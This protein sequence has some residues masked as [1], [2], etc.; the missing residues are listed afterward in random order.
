MIGRW[1]KLRAMSVRNSESKT[2]WEEAIV[3][4]EAVGYLREGRRIGESRLR[5]RSEFVTDTVMRISLA[6]ASVH[7]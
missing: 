4:S 5:R 7:V 2:M 6:S 1:S 3:R